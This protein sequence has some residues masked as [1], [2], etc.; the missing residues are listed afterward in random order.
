VIAPSLL[1]RAL[2][3]RQ[4]GLCVVV[5]RQDGSKAPVAEPLVDDQGEPIV[6]P[7]GRQRWGWERWQREMSS[8]DEI[9]RWYGAGHTG[10]GY[11][12]GT[13]SGNLEMFE[14]ED[15]HTYAAFMATARVL[16]LGDLVDRISAGY[17]SQTPG[18]G[19]HWLYRC[20]EIAGNTKLAQRP[21]RPEEKKHERDNVAVLIET[22]GQGGF[23]VEAPSN[24]TVHPS[25]GAYVQR[26]GGVETVLTLS[27]AERQ[28]IL[29][30]ARTFDEMPESLPNVGFGGPPR[31]GRL[32]DDFNERTTWRELLEP[33]GWTLAH[34][35]GSICYW[36]RPV[37]DRGYSAISG[38]SPEDRFAC[39]STST[40]LETGKGYSKFGYYTHRHHGGAFKAAARELGQRGYGDPAAPTPL[41]AVPQPPAEIEEPA[42]PWPLDVLPPALRRLVVE[43]AAALPCPPD[44]IAIP[45]LTA[46]GVAIGDAIELELKGGWREG[47]NIYTVKV[48]DPG[49]KKTPSDKLA[50]Q[51]LFRI[52]KQLAEAYADEKAAY[53]RAMNAWESKK[54]KDRG[55]KPEAPVFHHIVTT[56]ATVEAIAPMLVSGKG[57]VLWRE[58]LSGWVRSMDQ[59]RSGG[60]GADRQSYLSMW[61]RTLLKIDRK[62]S[63]EP[64]IVLRPF[65]AV[66]GGIQPDLIPGLADPESRED[67]F[68]DRILWAYP[69]PVRDVW[70]TEG[71]DRNT[72]VAVDHV[73]ARLYAL[74][75]EPD[76]DSEDENATRPRMVRLS[77]PA[78]QLW[79][80][81][82]HDQVAELEDES[83]PSQ[84]RGPWAKMP[85]QAARLA[86]ILHCVERV[87]ANENPAAFAVSDWALGGALELIDNYFKPHARR[88]Y[89]LLAHQRRD[90]VIRLLEA[91]KQSGPMLKRDILLGVFQGHVPAARVDAMLEELETAGLAVREEKQSESG[92]GRRGVWW[93]AA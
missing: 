86:L 73:F 72:I 59:Y 33:D 11:V 63:P 50:L 61:S 77:A 39:Y 7:D 31:S 56:D 35:R 27:I 47:A 22:R 9:R 40:D 38:Y 67:G 85:G 23:T 34:Q 21:K 78:M 8:E 25:G 44:F 24:G 2:A 42:A 17:E 18:G 81:W 57:I 32:I 19:I 41:R 90:Q 88:V 45:L 66:T 91:L 52:Q 3:A 80:S 54:P 58:E 92:K 4:A 62:S 48:G 37:K 28:H 16:G 60:K 30:L 26:Q 71:V 65:L 43:G 68:V 36:R 55:E 64:V 74:Q 14:F 29:A 79:A 15:E 51:P 83:F 46:A 6:G 89:R 70:T 82:Y 10:I 53:K 84:L 76:P 5:P 1:E 69:D 49:S 12:C 75:G 87:S 13:V 20:E 93:R